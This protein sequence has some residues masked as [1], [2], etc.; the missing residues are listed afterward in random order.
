MIEDSAERAVESQGGPTLSVAAQARTSDEDRGPTLVDRLIG[1]AVR[2]RTTVLVLLAALVV[3]GGWA[4]ATLRVDAFPELSNVQVE[5]LTEAPGMPPLEVERLVTYPIEVAVQG[6]PG[7]ATVRS[8]SRYGLSDVRIIFND[9]T[10]DYFARTRVSEQ[11]QAVRSDLPAGSR[12]Q[13]AP[14]S[15]SIG[16]IY[17]YTVSDTVSGRGESLMELRTIQDR[18]VRPQLRAVSGVAD[19]NSFGGDVRQVS[20]TVSPE[21]L[22]AYGITLDDVVHAVQGNTLEAAGGYIAHGDQQYILRGL[23][24]AQN[25]DDVRHTVIRSGAAGAPVTVGD[26]AEVNYGAEVRQ[27]AVSMNGRGEVV[28]GIV[29]ALRGENSRLLVR[30]IASK[31]DEI[32]RALPPGVVVRPYYDQTKL[33]EGTLDTVRH[34][35]L[36][37]GF[38]VIAILLLFLGNVRAALVVAATIPLSLLAAFLGMRWL[39]LSANLMSLGAVDFGMIVDG[40]VVMVEHFIKALYQE[41]MSGHYPRGARALRSRITALA[42]EVGRP[43][44]FGVLIIMLVYVPIVTLQ[45]L[46]GRMFRPMAITVAMA[47]FGSLLLA[48]AAVPALATLVFRRGARESRLALRMAEWLDGR[49]TPLLKR[50]MG[51]PTLTVLTAVALF[52]ASL[53][54]VP[55]LGTEF[56]PELQ[57]GSIQITAL[58]DPGVSLAQSLA[59]EHTLERVVLE[60]PEVETILSQVGRAEIAS[61]P[62]G[63]DRAEIF[64]MLKPS[65]AWRGG[66][67]QQ[68]IQQEIEQHLEAQVSGLSLSFSQPVANRLDEITSGVRA[69]LAVKVFGDDAG[70][71][72]RVAEQIAGVVAH[73]PGA[74]EVQLQATSGQTYLNVRLDR[75]AMSRYGIPL[76]AAQAALNA[77]VSGNAVAQVAEGNFTIN[78][79]VQYPDS[80]RSSPDAIASITVEGSAGARVPLR[81]FA[82]I[83]LDPG[84]I[85]INREDGQRLEIVQANVEGRDLGGFAAAVQQAVAKDVQLPPGVFVRYGGQF[86]NQQRAMA[87]LKV[88]VPMSIAVIAML[89]YSS[90]GS[91]L[92]A[93][94][95]LLN[96]PFA[97]V[98]GIAALWL[99]GLHLSISASIGFVALFGVAVLNGLVLLTTV[100]REHTEGVEAHEA[101]LDGARARLRPVLMTALVASIGF[102]PVAVSHGTGAEVQRPLATVVIGGLVTS[103][104]LTLLV[105]PTLYAWAVGAIERRRRH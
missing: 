56:L 70:V 86:E 45:G 29:M 23:G 40:S 91:W 27:G 59:M 41:E 7:V 14:L 9:G 48:L 101:A 50:T 53:L 67:T 93:G 77:A 73:V 13:L 62:A 10:D 99:R 95:V 25:A 46:E 37:G 20:V 21:R 36:E 4:L 44:L 75:S 43:I 71:N 1:W 22:A 19:V 98:G 18:I 15:G 28:T 74:G 8:L 79:A 39:G 6:I 24:Q 76:D 30:R 17:Q 83:T 84:P 11:L 64:V 88:V 82:T 87:R 16:E 38:L 12:S 52:A 81:N 49:Y 26:V 85:Q 63:V 80:L 72:R 34:N 105:L 57:E 92:L 60:T 90:L 51:R 69:D 89:L 94:I 61:D 3:A 103:T 104:L 97:A 42:Q 54:I 78:V 47:L 55:H 65:S 5:V 102:I 31:V 32:N 35:L 66:I 58:R 68:Q 96:L 100:Q 33:V 2:N